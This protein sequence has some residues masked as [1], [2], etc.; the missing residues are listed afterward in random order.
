MNQGSLGGLVFYDEIGGSLITV[1]KQPPPAITP[2][3]PPAKCDGDILDQAQLQ[4]R[5]SFLVEG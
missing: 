2:A 1:L 3:V 4:R 5:D